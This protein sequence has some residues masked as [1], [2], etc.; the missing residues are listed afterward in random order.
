MNLNGG[1]T[2][3]IAGGRTLQLRVDALNVFNNET[4]ADPNLNPTSTQLVGSPPNGQYIPFVTFV[5]NFSYECDFDAE[6]PGRRGE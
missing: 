6:T 5:M 4:D 2:I 3:R 1:R